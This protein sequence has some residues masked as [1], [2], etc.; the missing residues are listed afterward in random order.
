[1][2]EKTEVIEKIMQLS[3]NDYLAI[4]ISLFFSLRFIISFIN[5]FYRPLKRASLNDKSKLISVLIPARN[6]EKNIGN[7]LRNLIDQ[8]YKNLEIIVYND[9]SEDSTADIVNKMKAKDDRIKIINGKE[10]EKNWLGKNYACYKLAKEAKGEYYIFIDADVILEPKLVEYT[11]KYVNENKL[12]LLSIFP[13]QIMKSRGEKI[14][15]PIMNFILLSLLPLPLLKIRNFFKSLSAA[16]GQFMFF[17][18]GVYEKYQPHKLMKNN[19]TED[20]SIA[21]LLKAKKEKIRCLANVIEIK[22]RMY[23]SF[24]ESANGFSKNIIN[25]LMGN[26]TFAIIFFLFSAF[27]LIFLAA[28]NLKL[29]IIVFILNLLSHYFIS[30]TSNIN[31]IVQTIFSV[32]RIFALAYIIYLSIIK[33]I[34]KEN[35]WKGRNIYQ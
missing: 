22:C 8:T 7:L 12:A 33:K 13:N 30:K 4:I 6:E 27:G 35:Q 16:N 2:S 31:L 34:K 28:Y 1:M 9:M 20:I 26:Y 17:N 18:A 11:S 24:Q 29:F 15:V 14:V 3:I 10:L 25:M 32:P 19:S 5:Y 21:R 23:N